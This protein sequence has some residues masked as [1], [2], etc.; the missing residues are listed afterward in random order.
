MTV[1]DRY[2]VRHLLGEGGLGLVYLA[3]DQRL[4]RWVAIKRLRA[5][6]GDAAL[7]FE[8]AMQ[9]A[10]TLA[11]AHHPNIVAIYDFGSDAD[12]PYVVMEYVEGETLEARV[13]RGAMDE[14]T[15]ALM[16]RQVLEGITAAH[17]KGVVH[18]DL[19]PGNIMLAKSATG[20]FHVKILDFGLAKVLHRPSVQSA[21][22]GDSLFG[23]I[24]CMAPEQF[25]REP[26]DARTDLYSLGCIFYEALTGYV[27]FGGETV[28]EVMASHLAHN[29]I[30][31]Q[32]VKPDITPALSEWVMRLIAN[33]A[34]DRPPHAAAALSQFDRIYERSAQEFT[35]ST[36]TVEVPPREQ[37]SSG[38][39]GRWLLVGALLAGTLAAFGF[40]FFKPS[41]AAPS[42]VATQAVATPTPTPVVTPTPMQSSRPEV[43]DPL[44]LEKLRP[45]VGKKVTVGGTIVD[46][47][48]SKS[49]DVFYLN[50]DKN[51]RAA[52]SLVFFKK[53]HPGLSLEQ[54]NQYVGKSVEASGELEKYRDNLQI[55]MLSLDQLR[56]EQP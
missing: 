54:L 21:D 2:E 19:K 39:S 53:S 37:V 13:A 12:G 40:F 48:A 3:W 31:I 8:K 51:Y 25:N 16:A 30:P 44:A 52:V 45:L 26:V 34:K 46:T 14:S 10:L 5:T 15:F 29:V 7:G 38:A 9:E 47:G 4:G 55:Q 6:H 36:I 18:R 35:P 43:L 1:A 17:S 20:L 11:S 49:G 32:Q 23:S 56:F 22:Q 33:K 50:F 41:P 28:A 24:Y 42:V 27:P